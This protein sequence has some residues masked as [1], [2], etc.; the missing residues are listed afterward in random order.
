VEELLGRPIQDELAEE[1][2]VDVAL[3][4]LTDVSTAART[5][6]GKVEGLLTSCLETREMVME[7][8]EQLADLRMQVDMFRQQ[9]PTR[10]RP[11]CNTVNASGLDVVLRLD[12]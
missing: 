7:S 3:D 8:R 5:M 1:T 9:C 11:L 10:F 2:G 6:S 12:A 4:A